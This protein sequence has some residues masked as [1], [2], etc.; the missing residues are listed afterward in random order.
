MA[1]V[2]LRA[3]ARHRGVSLRAVQKAIASGRIEK[4]PTGQVDTEVADRQWQSRTAPRPVAAQQN[5]PPQSQPRQSGR[6]DV[7]QEPESNLVAHNQPRYESRGDLPATSSLDYSRARAVNETYRAKLT[8]IEFEER[9]EKL[10]SRDEVR[11]AAHNKYRI[12]RDAMLNIPD[13]V[14]AVVASEGDSAKVHHILTT[15]IRRALQEFADGTN[16]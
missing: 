10:V 11:V 15:E 1:L 13:R 4:T 5:R 12:F 7:S 14:A 16:R 2:S 9:S 6:G 3:Y 8:K